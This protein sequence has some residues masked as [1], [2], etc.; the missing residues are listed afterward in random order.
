V[1]WPWARHTITTTNQLEYGEADT[2][3][4]CC[5]QQTSP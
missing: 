1:Q 2:F 5:S 3:V 4:V